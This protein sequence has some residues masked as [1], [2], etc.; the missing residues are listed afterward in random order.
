M[1]LVK[2]L[3]RGLAV[4]K[5]VKRALSCKWRLIQMI[6]AKVWMVILSFILLFPSYYCLQGIW[7]TL[8]TAN[9]RSHEG[10][11]V[12]GLMWLYSAAVWIPYILILGYNWKKLS[13]SFKL[14][15]S[16]STVVIFASFIYSLAVS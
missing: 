8:D 5:D 9:S 11:L 13:R 2:L 15:C 7:V 4:R 14:T 6:S 10:N 1:C 12:I 3:Q 16:L